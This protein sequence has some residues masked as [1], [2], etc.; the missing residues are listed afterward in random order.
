[1]LYHS[2]P[3][4]MGF[5]RGVPHAPVVMPEGELNIPLANPKSDADALD[6][7]VREILHRVQHAKQACFLP[8]YLTRRYGCV[9]QAKALIEASGLLFFTGVQDVGVLSQQHPQFG[10]NY[11]GRFME[12]VPAVSDYVEACDCI[13]GIGPENH[14]FN[15][16]FHTVDYDFKSTIN[17]MPHRTRVGM[18]TYENVEMADV[19]TAL[20]AKIGKSETPTKI[21]ITKGFGAPTG[22]A[23]DKI[24]Y[25]PL[26]ERVQAFLKPNDIFVIDTAMTSLAMIGRIHELPEGVDIEAQCSWGAIGWGTPETLGNCLADRSRRCIVLAGEGGHQMTAP[27]MGTFAKYGAKPIF[28]LA[29]NFGYLGERVTNRYPDE[30]YNDTAPWDFPAVA[31]AMGCK[32]WLLETVTTLGELDAALAKAASGDTGAYIEMQIDPY[33]CPKGADDFYT[34]TGPFFGMKG[35]KWEDWLKE[36]AAKKKK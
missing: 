26:Y 10:G 36:L 13:I 8:G 17:I 24:T 29:N 19:L 15:N 28:L 5:P 22:E 34:L 4:Y 18:G 1:M 32:D 2:K 23:G 30:S 21:E 14:E 25:E 6:A 11:L 3:I 20:A 27:E 7:V 35:R 12:Y 33:E 31:A 9:D 16:G